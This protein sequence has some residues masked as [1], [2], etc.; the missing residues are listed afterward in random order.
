MP[1]IISSIFSFLGTAVGGLF[2]FKGEQ[3][4][5]VQ[6]A[7]E[8]LQGLNDTEAQSVVAQA[9]AI[10]SIL[11]NGSFL[12]RNWRAAFMVILIA[13]LVASFFGY[14]PPNFNDKLSP[15]MERIFNLLEI[16][17]GGYIVRYGVRDMV[18]EFNIAG[19]IKQ[20]ISKKVL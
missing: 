5:T 4:K 13:I 12:E 17:L 2:G 8:T 11:N 18:R 3:A 9:Q 15:M 10:S 16:G 19:I 1:A 7:L 14:V 20:V 6:K